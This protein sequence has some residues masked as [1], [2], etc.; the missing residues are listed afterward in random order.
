[1]S[2]GQWPTP[3][4]FGRFSP[5]TV[6]RTTLRELGSKRWQIICGLAACAWTLTSTRSTALGEWT[7]SICS[8]EPQSDAALD[9]A[10]LRE[11]CPLR[12]LR[13]IR[14]RQ[15]FPRQRRSGEMHSAI[16]Y[17]G[18]LTTSSAH[19]RPGPRPQEPPLPLVTTGATPMRRSVVENDTPAHRC[20]T[21]SG[22]LDQF[23]AWHA[24][25]DRD[26]K[27]RPAARAFLDLGHVDSFFGSDS[28]DDPRAFDP[29]PL[30]LDPQRERSVQ[31]FR[32][33]RSESS[34]AEHAE[35][36]ALQFDC[37]HTRGCSC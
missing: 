11:H 1:V 5:S 30:G 15:A 34:A 23:R 35:H 10:A 27:R 4:W 17:G 7:E 6:A 22:A 2:R 25:L 29:K 31:P 20:L 32:D 12:P 3:L 8:T 28:D 36:L 14:I 26:H 13:S 16:L 19:P 18:S 33:T 9:L 21:A 24:V 37:R